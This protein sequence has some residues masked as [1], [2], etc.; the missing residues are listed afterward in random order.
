MARNGFQN[1]SFHLFVHP[2]PNQLAAK[3]YLYTSYFFHCFI[4]FSD[5]ISHIAAWPSY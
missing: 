4:Q 3:V 5:S 1:G 2:W